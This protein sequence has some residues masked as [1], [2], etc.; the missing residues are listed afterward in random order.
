[1][2][3]DIINNPF[4]L[5]FWIP[6]VVVFLSAPFII[7][8]CYISGK[9]LYKYL[10]GL[11]GHADVEPPL[12]IKTML[13]FITCGTV[14]LGCIFIAIGALVMGGLRILSGFSSNNKYTS[15]P[16]RDVDN[17]PYPIRKPIDDPGEYSYQGKDGQWYTSTTRRDIADEKYDR[18]HGY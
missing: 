5:I 8:L 6:L 1:M 12:Y 9:K 15:Y 13:F 18:E 17:E 7:W 3:N 14:T 2:M 11:A 10:E 4:H 16:A